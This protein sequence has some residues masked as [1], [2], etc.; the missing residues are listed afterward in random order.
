VKIAMLGGRGVPAHYSGSETCVEEVGARLALRGHEVVVYCRRHNSQIA[1]AVYRGMRR[2]VLPSLNSKH[3]DTPTHTLLALLHNYAHDPAD[4][5]HFHG[6]G[7]SLFLPWIK[8]LPG[9]K[10]ITVDGPDWERPKWGPVARRVLKVSARLA[11]SLADI[12]I[13]DSRTSQ[14]YYQQ[15]FQRQ[16]CYIPYG[17]DATPVEASGALSQYG[18]EQRRYILF[19]GRLVPDK[20]VH[21]LVEAFREIKTDLQLV[22]VGDSPLFS[23]YI[24]QLKSTRDPRI[25]FLGFVFDEPYRQ[26]C[27]HAYVYVQPSLVEGTSPA[28]LAAMGLGNCVVVN[29]IPENLETVGHAGLSFA[30][31]DL[32]DLRRVLQQL[33]DDPA[34]VEHYRV[35]AR[36]R[37]KEV[38][39]W[40]TIALTHEELYQSILGTPAPLAPHRAS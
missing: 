18:L 8:L 3:L 1:D 10:V 25:R 15:H 35:L 36:Q 31:H 28:L 6:V 24:Q 9:K 40:D 14:Q 34:L 16:T 21:L 29:S 30:R 20:G 23:D 7:N 27:A 4:I 11:M 2:V 22:I 12:V 5:L 38:F 39:S 26:L 19:V 17:A 13:N 32:R 37:V 33:I